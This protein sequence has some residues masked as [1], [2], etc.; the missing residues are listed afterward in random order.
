MSDLFCA[1][2]VILAR[3]GEAKY[4]D[5]PAKADS[6]GELTLAGRDQARRLGESLRSRRVAMVYASDLA[7]SVQTA[8]IAAGVLNVPVRI[9]GN[10]REFGIGDLAGRPFDAAMFEPVIEKWRSGDLSQ[11]CPGAESG[12]DVVARVTEVLEGIVDDHRGETVLVVSHS[13]ALQLTLPTLAPTGF[14]VWGVE[15]G[16][17]NCDQVEMLADADGWVLRTWN[18]QPLDTSGQGVDSTASEAAQ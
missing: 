18:G 6:G 11:G 17:G 5:E 3:H 8:E 4:H 10:L 12:A 14:D 13:G 1:A 2:T 9:R 15:H 7:R 16:L